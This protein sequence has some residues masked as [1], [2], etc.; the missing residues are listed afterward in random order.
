MP[1]Y[2]F[3]MGGYTM[4]FTSKCIVEP[5]HAHLN[6]TKHKIIA[7]SA[8][9]WVG[10][11]GETQVVHTGNVPNKVIKEARAWIKQNYKLMKSKWQAYGGTTDFYANIAKI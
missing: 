6:D 4:Y 7:G 9:I 10:P 8:K 5:I 1:D 2:G 11:N 3:T